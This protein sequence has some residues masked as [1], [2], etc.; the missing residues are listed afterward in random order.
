MNDRELA[1]ELRS[2]YDQAKR[3]EAACQIH[4]FGIK[5]AEELLQCGS[6]LKH[7]LEL[8]GIPHGYLSEISKGIKLAQYVTIRKEGNEDAGNSDR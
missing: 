4:L 3:N 2:M 5:Y 8:S 1:A 6:P 7:I